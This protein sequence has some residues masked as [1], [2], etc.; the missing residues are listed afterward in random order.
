MLMAAVGCLLP[1]AL[2]VIGA[3]IG[4]VIGGTP[5]GLWGAGIGAAIGVAA[6]LFVLRWFE[7]ARANWP[8]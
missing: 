1:F 6:M 7:R 3:I 8:E 4:G 2:L 5:D